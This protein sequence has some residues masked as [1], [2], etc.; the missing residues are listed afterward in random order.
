M[1]R[2]RKEAPQRKT[3]LIIFRVTPSEYDFLAAVAR[4]A[5]LSVHT[6]ARHSTLSKSKRLVIECSQA[7]D[8]ALLKRL[9]RIG[10]NLNQLVRRFHQSG[11]LSKMLTP[12]CDEIAQIV[13]N[14]IKGKDEQ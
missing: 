7:S 11:R 10:N 9:E 8:P 3:Q 6:L 4:R 14:D 2:P 1:G 13:Y 5:G 12:L